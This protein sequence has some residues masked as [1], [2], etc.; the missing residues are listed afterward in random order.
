[1]QF[2]NLARG[3]A[4]EHRFEKAAG[5]A[6]LAKDNGYP[7]FIGYTELSGPAGSVDVRQW[8][9]K[10]MCAQY[11]IVLWSQRSVAVDG[12]LGAHGNSGGGI[13]LLVHKRLR[14]SAR[15][16]HLFASEDELAMLDGHLRVWRFDAAPGVAQ[17]L[18][19]PIIITLAYFPPDDRKW[20]KNARALMA[21]AIND[22]GH[23]IAEM[24]LVEDICP[25]MMMHTNAPDGGCPVELLTAETQ[26]WSVAALEQLVQRGAEWAGNGEHCGVLSVKPGGGSVTIERAFSE[27]QKQRTSTLGVELVN[28]A[29]RNRMCPGTGV[30]SRAQETTWNKTG[31]ETG[32]RCDACKRGDTGSCVQ[33]KKKGG[34]AN[35]TCAQLLQPASFHDQMWFA[36]ELVLRA[37]TSPRGGRDFLSFHTKRIIWAPGCPI[38]HAVTF[39]RIHVGR[40]TRLALEQ[41]V[42]DV[43]SER[44]PRRKR[45]PDDLLARHVMKRSIADESDNRFAILADC[46]LYA[47]QSL[48]EQNAVIVDTL[49]AVLREAHEARSDEIGTDAERHDTPTIRA[50]RGELAARRGELDAFLRAH[51]LGRQRPQVQ[52]AP[53]DTRRERRRL[54]KAVTSVQ[55]RMQRTAFA[56]NGACQS[57][58]RRR[59][60]LAYWRR[61][62]ITSTDLGAPDMP[63]MMLLDHQTDEK[64]AL[65]TANASVCEKNMRA[66][67]AELYQVP[68]EL[69]AECEAKIDEALAELHLE[70]ATI[71]VNG[72][73]ELDSAAARSAL[74]P[75]AP[76][77]VS[78]AQRGVQRSLAAAIDAAR[79]RRATANHPLRRVLNEHADAAAQLVRAITVPELINVCLALDDVGAGTDGLPPGML[80]LLNDGPA[81]CVIARLLNRCL[82]GG[83]LPAKW[84]QHRTLFLYKKEDPFCL[85]NY[86]GIS[87]DS[88]LLK[89]YGLLLRTRLEDFVESTN[90]LSTMQGGF[91][92][93]RGP[94]ESVLTLSE[95]VRASLARSS[96]S[97]PAGGGKTVEAV[98]VDVKVAYDSVLHTILWKRCM[99][100]GI[101]GLF[102]AALQAMYCDASSRVDVKG[103]LLEPVPLLRGVLQGNPLSPLLF[104]IY[105]D[106]TIAELNALEVYRGWRYRPLGLWLPS[107]ASEL[108]PHAATHHDYLPCL[109][110]A[111]DGV[112]LEVDHAQLQR[113]LDVLAASLAASG[114]HINVK[115]TKWMLIPLPGVS[116]KAYMVLKATALKNPLTVYGEA[117]ELVDEFDY[118]GVRVW[119]RWNYVRA[120]KAAAQ[121]ARKAYFG[122]VRGGWQRRAG[123]LASQ[124]DFARAKIFCHFNYVAALAGFAGC[125]SS[126]AWADGD[127]VVGWALRTISGLHHANVTALK[128]EAGVWDNGMHQHMLVLRFWRKC[129]SMPADAA[130]VRAIRLSM[131]STSENARS[132]PASCHNSITQLHRQT[133]AQQVFAAAAR[134][135][136]PRAD[137]ESG[138][139]DLVT[140]QAC[141][142][143]AAVWQTVTAALPVAPG[144]RVRLVVTPLHAGA[145]TDAV[146]G[147]SCWALPDG[148][149]RDVAL[150]KW[151]GALK[152]AVYASLRARGNHSRHAEVTAF[153]A[154][155]LVPDRHTGRLPR[156]RT[157][158]ATVSGSLMQPY[159]HLNDN[160]LARWLLMAR[161]DSCPNEDYFRAVPHHKLARILERC[162]RA[163]Y[164]CGA[165]APDVYWPETLAHTLVCCTHARLVHQRAAL[166]TA[167]QALADSD[168][169]LALTARASVP[170]AI[171]DFQDDSVLFTVLQMCTGVGSDYNAGGLHQV[172]LPAF[173]DAAAQRAFPQFRRVS[174]RAREAIA[175]MGPL[176]EDWLAILREPR[177]QERPHDAPGHQLA[178]LVARHVQGVFGTRSAALNSPHISA[179]FKARSRDPALA[180]GAAAAPAQQ[181]Q[182]SSPPSSPLLALQPSSG[183]SSPPA[184]PL[185]PQRQVQKQIPRASVFSALAVHHVS[186]SQRSDCA[187]RA[188]VARY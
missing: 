115:K 61:Q 158:A 110:F 168:G 12:K 24:R 185:S 128:I 52:L 137:V 5:L 82:Q 68:M 149:T 53:H 162:R 26:T 100:K 151:T 92:R 147:T 103:K 4:K 20:G 98:F 19:K 76:C 69:S 188:V 78:D 7:D 102:L 13:A 170:I 135:D 120:V 113:M 143:L 130:F 153:L 166:R 107:R 109:F 186:G 14:V 121:R 173:A 31:T 175:W 97:A 81:A 132:A 87:I 108:Q 17:P 74:D 84:S 127:K 1:M 10:A 160:R 119:W 139:P 106:G 180:I 73:L 64:G 174:A 55:R 172:P 167:L 33:K 101:G 134:F 178:A 54:N 131:S 116:E 72:A 70:N 57:D 3:T 62:V 117:V 29:A 38:D 156:L 56:A 159:W 104:N 8:I 176:C 118:L 141:S 83:G 27:K 79:A 77:A 41:G 105:L 150:T 44:Q 86:R 2:L 75:Y 187:L 67:R 146:E 50:L 71:H 124:L 177:R 183:H 125:K 138:T 49:H 34:Y 85:G 22:S 133:W 45:F 96:K 129:H 42:S 65:V 182:P 28:S 9:G 51:V 123:S 60:P 171:P 148:T 169:A 157:W 95:T 155:Q 36:S 164:L 145:P 37:R 43:E 25:V 126:T 91:R 89:L 154:A 136:I 181:Q 94:P 93:L 6:K 30:Q 144:D 40:P 88:V 122:A 179:S 142:P 63:V 46:S 163:C 21:R 111:D 48:D 35:S 161:F 90:A 152:A 47:A 140:V 114:L 112:L 39:A 80:S 165:L 18:L 32:G 16:L 58:A 15:E 99:D 23:A 184:S 66:N 11:N 59:A